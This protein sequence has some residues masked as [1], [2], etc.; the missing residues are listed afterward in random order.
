[1]ER[2]FLSSIFCTP[3]ACAVGSC[4]CASD[5]SAWPQHSSS[6]SHGDV[7]DAVRRD[8]T[9]AILAA[10]Q[11]LH[12]QAT[13]KGELQATKPKRPHTPL[14]SGIKNEERA[15][16]KPPPY[17]VAVDLDCTQM[18]PTM[19]DAEHVGSESKTA[20]SSS[21]APERVDH[22]RLEPQPISRHLGLDS[23]MAL[24]KGNQRFIQN[25]RNRS[26][27]K[28]A[29]PLVNHLIQAHQTVPKS[30]KSLINQLTQAPFDPPLRRAIVISCARS[31]YPLESLFNLHPGE[32]QV[33]RVCGYVSKSH[34]GV[35]GSVEFALTTGEAPPLLLVLG[36]SDNPVVAD[37]VRVALRE[38]G[39]ED[40]GALLEAVCDSRH[41]RKLLPAARDALTSEP[42][43]SFSR[44]CDLAGHLNVWSTIETLLGESLV[45]HEQVAQGKLLVHGAYLEV[46]SGSVTFMGAHPSMAELM[47]K[48]PD[49]VVARTASMPFVP[50]DEAFA[51]CVAGNA[52]Y[53]RGTSGAIDLSDTVLM[54]R[55]AEGGQKPAAVVLG[56][57]DSRAPIEILFD[58][59]PGDLFVLRNAGNTCASARGSVIGSAEYAVANLGTKAVLVV[60]H[61]KCGAVTAA[62]QTVRAAAVQADGTIDVRSLD[63]ATLNLDAVPGSIGNVLKD[64]VHAAVMA[65]KQLPQA[66]E[67]EQVALA[68]EMNV[69]STIEKLLTYSDIVRNEVISGRAQCYGGVYNI[70]SRDIKWLGI[71]PEIERIVGCPMPVCMWKQAPYVPPEEAMMPRSEKA[72][73]ALKNLQAGNER[74]IHSRS[75]AS[76][77]ISHGST[78]AIILA[79]SEV[80]VPIENIFDAR[81]GDL[82]VQRC[83]GNIAGGSLG[84]LFSSLEYAVRKWSPPLLVVMGES[85]SSIIENALEQLA[86]EKPL[87]APRR[88]ILD[89][90]MVSAL[91]ASTQASAEATLSP[92]ARDL[93]KR[94][95]AVR[96]NI[97]YTIEQLLRSNIIA[98]AV[99]T[100]SLEI[101]GAVLSCTTGKVEFLG[102]HPMQE[103]ILSCDGH[104]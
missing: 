11:R 54:E 65:V 12:V 104:V 81:P 63:A 47:L 78:F 33:V 93:M 85:H 15:P 42:H 103:E 69:F 99:A 77:F 26:T 4:A 57:A 43:A 94:A 84:T 3:C 30:E 72:I 19:E 37:A 7:T 101:H 38:A 70:T 2:A 1:M 50:Y 32:L 88:G 55:L 97:L 51:S 46:S 28:R 87:L 34:D 35:L 66:T 56:C 62:V 13:D 8:L 45:V 22:P 86:G 18:A 96:L 95:L 20:A 36:N 68:A 58:M 9:D 21:D 59:R 74:F 98:E 83:M 23:L 100:H 76:S 29:L 52:R 79:G 92:A 5:A 24:V 71:H 39:R 75:L 89:R 6:T 17:P 61:S 80:F 48:A 25:G 40:D 31:F 102:E 10:V 82:I 41:V 44:L 49:P 91:R 14:A 67:S 64:I 27:S 73:E 60:G 16:A 53:L 90:V